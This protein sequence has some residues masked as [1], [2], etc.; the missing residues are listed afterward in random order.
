MGEQI[1]PQPVTNDDRSGQYYYS[2]RYDDMDTTAKMGAH[3]LFTGYSL[4]TDWVVE[5]FTKTIKADK[6]FIGRLFVMLTTEGVALYAGGIQHEVFGHGYRHREAGNELEHDFWPFP[7]KFGQFEIKKYA[8]DYD[9]NDEIMATMGGLEATQTLSV[10]TGQN[11]KLYGGNLSRAML[12]LDTHLDISN[13]IGIW[14]NPSIGDSSLIPFSGKEQSYPSMEGDINWYWYKMAQKEYEHLRKNKTEKEIYDEG[15]WQGPNFSYNA[16]RVG[17][18]YNLLDPYTLYLAFQSLKYLFKGKANFDVPD[19][20][21]RTNFILSPNGPEYYL[22]LP[23]MAGKTLVEPYVR[24]TFNK[25]KNAFGAGVT[26]RN[27]KLGSGRTKLVL[28]GGIHLWKD[29][30]GIG[31]SGELGLHSNIFAKL[32]KP[33]DK[34]YLGVTATAKTEGYMMAQP[35]EAGVSGAATL[36]YIPDSGK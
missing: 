10:F 24:T 28:D 19:F 3:D 35:V 7:T 36:S 16:I 13:Y 26:A 18:I 1:M 11:I 31:V 20:L 27:F 22:T 34:V 8:A 33:L 29:K 21:P 14:N 30:D 17:A 32:A 25:D 2:L 5:P 23:F 4:I 12:Y 6:K 9:L 15:L